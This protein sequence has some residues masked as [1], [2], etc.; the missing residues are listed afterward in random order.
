MVARVPSWEGQ[1]MENSV[2]MGLLT[3]LLGFALAALSPGQNMVTVASTALGAG[4][5]PALL[6]ASGIAT[7]A[8]L[9]S[10]CMSYGLAR[11]F[12]LYPWTLTVL[13]LVGGLYL[14]YLAYKGIR[15]AVNGGS[16]MIAPGQQVDGFNAWLRGLIVTASN[17]KVAL[18]WA[19]IATYVTSFTTTDSILVTFAFAVAVTA[20]LIYGGY[21]LVF[22]TAQSRRIYDR[23]KSVFEAGFGLVFG[24]LGVML[25]MSQF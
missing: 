3:A 7:G 2:Y 25:L 19:S 24:A 10:L 22:S 13:S 6:A 23:S 16:A 14:L 8:F 11:L 21:A 5:R 15:A 1:E 17:P 9:C 12:E 20:M 18:F 4:R